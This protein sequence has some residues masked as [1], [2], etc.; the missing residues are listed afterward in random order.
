MDA[1]QLQH[2]LELYQ[3]GKVGNFKLDTLSFFI[4]ASFYTFSSVSGKMLKFLSQSKK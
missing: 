4:A 3:A 2:A 1:G